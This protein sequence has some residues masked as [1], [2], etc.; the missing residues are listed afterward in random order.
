MRESALDELFLLD[1]SV[2]L[3]PQNDGERGQKHCVILNEVKIQH[4]IIVLHHLLQ[5]SEEQGR[6]SSVENDFPQAH[7]TFAF[8]FSNTILPPIGVVT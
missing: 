1:S 7:F 5:H 4:V 6:E 2:A 3:L 8:G